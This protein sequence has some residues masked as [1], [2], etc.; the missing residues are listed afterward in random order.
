MFKFGQESLFFYLSLN[1]CVFSVEPYFEE[2]STVLPKVPNVNEVN[3]LESKS[4]HNL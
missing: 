4:L 3:Y 1:T 2:Y